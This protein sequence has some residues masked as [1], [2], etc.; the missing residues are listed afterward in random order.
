MMTITREMAI[1]TGK[2]IGRSSADWALAKDD[3]P[4]GWTGLTQQ[5][6]NSLAADGI[7]EESSTMDTIA[8]FAFSEYNA[9][10][11]AAL[12]AEEIAARMVA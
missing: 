10:I 7:P 3:R 8:L 5:T 4:I 1:A 11:N 12:S 9:T 2:A 6:I